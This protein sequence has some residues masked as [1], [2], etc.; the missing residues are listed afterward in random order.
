MINCPQQN[1][2]FVPL[3]K[4]ASVVIISRFS[5]FCFV[6]NCPVMVI[7]LGTTLRLFPQ[8]NA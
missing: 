6:D 3:S 8:L 1:R 4:I 7:A 5:Q 2:Q